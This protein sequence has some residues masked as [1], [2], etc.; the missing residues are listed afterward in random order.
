MSDSQFQTDSQSGGWSNEEWRNLLLAI[1]NKQCT[2][3]LGAGASA[4]VIP[5]GN[6]IA[7]V[8][9]KDYEY[10]FRHRYNLT[11]V[12]Q[13][14]AVAVAETSPKFKVKEIIETSIQ[15]NGLPKFEDPDE[16]HRVLAELPFSV[17][18][19]TNYDDFMFQALEVVS[20]SPRLEIC[21]WNEA[22]KQRTSLNDAS[23]E[24]NK[25]LPVPNHP[26]VYHLHGHLDDTN[27]IVISEDDYLNF[28]IKISEDSDLIPGYV[29]PAFTN[30][31]FLFIGY[32]LEDMNFKVLFRKFAGEMLRGTG[33]RHVSVQ[34]APRRFETP[35]K[36]KARAEKQIEYLQKQLSDQKVKVYWG[37]ANE[38]AREL[39]KR[40][41]GGLF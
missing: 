40:W 39:R 26:V 13:Y 18:I 22:K 35:M 38:F 19:T 8:M 2:P 10:P 33:D 32:S 11:R 4:G 29:A 27:S 12:A 5:T 41:K 6:A 9:A 20:K 36:L 24:E 30:S 15:L 28:L 14:G 7:K 23:N 3:F 25:F 34:I 37:S 17:Y 21:R 31:T 16:L 1:R